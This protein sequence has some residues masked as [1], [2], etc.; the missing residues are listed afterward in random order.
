[1]LSHTHKGEVPPPPQH[2]KVKVLSNRHIKANRYRLALKVPSYFARA[3]PGQFMHLRIGDGLSPFLRRPF[4]ISN[5]TSE[6]IEI[7][8]KVVG[9]GTRILSGVKQ[10]ESLDIL[11]PLGSGFFICKETKR[12]LLIGGGMGIAPLIF[13][14]RRIMEEKDKDTSI[15]AFL[16]FKREGEI[17]CR[18]E[19]IRRGIPLHIA[20]ED[21]SFGYKGFVSELVKD[22]LKE[23]SF[24]SGVSIYVCGP[25]EM[26]KVVARLGF[27][28]NISSQ[29][30]MEEI[31]GC[32]IGACRGCVVKGTAGYLRVCREGPVF[33]ARDILWE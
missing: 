32:G 6:G 31:I 13:L 1:M 10:K 26:L 23:A 30:L 25:R 8:Y 11:G 22:Y 21:G 18:E 4:S 5:V 15:L 19:F 24:A 20:T 14:A 2:I 12:H 27:D 16:G 28:Y 29:V 9:R 7:V 17:I 33:N 3:L